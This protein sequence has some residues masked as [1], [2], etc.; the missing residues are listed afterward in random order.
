VATRVLV[1]D[2]GHHLRVGVDVGGRD[3]AVGAEHDRDAL[4]EAAREA[5]QLE[6]GKLLR[7][8]RHAALG[9]PEWDVHE[10][11]LPR[12]DGREAE[13]FVVVRLGVVPDATLA[14]SACAVVLDAVAGEHLDTAIVHPHRHFHLDFAE[15][16]HQD[17]PHVLL[18]VD[19]V[20]GALELARDDGLPRHRARRLAG[21]GGG[22]RTSAGFR[23]S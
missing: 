2:P 17:V 4:G 15:R 18:E 8:H 7:V 19:Q 12:H 14:W 5:L 20:G 3:V 13:H 22:H 16:V 23:R 10:R 6:L 11:G 1:Q 21:G 9:A